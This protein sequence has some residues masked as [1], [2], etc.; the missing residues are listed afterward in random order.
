[1]I[2]GASGYRSKCRIFADILRVVQKEERAKVTYILHEANLPYKRLIIHLAQM[3]EKG[4]IEIRLE[5]EK[6]YYAI[7]KKG[8]RYLVRFKAVEEFGDAFG[9]EI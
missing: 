7:T 3:E 8:E 1:M 6:K 9:M 4:L 5:D 2:D